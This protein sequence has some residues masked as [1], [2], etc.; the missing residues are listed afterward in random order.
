[1]GHSSA[2]ASSCAVLALLGGLL[3]AQTASA[4]AGGSVSV[5]GSVSTGA[6]AQGSAQASPAAPA[7]APAA[8]TPAAP[9]AAPDAAPAPDVDDAA[10]AAEWAERDS[11][12]NESNTITG[13]SGLLHTQPK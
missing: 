6:G 7:P 11:A 3:V 10:Q 8:A 13:G 4:Q 5:G 9:D 1:M 12:I 2:C